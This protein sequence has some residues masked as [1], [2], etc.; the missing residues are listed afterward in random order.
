MPGDEEMDKISS[1]FNE[2]IIWYRV[3][4]MEKTSGPGGECHELLSHLH[5]N[6]VLLIET[7]EYTLHGGQMRGLKAD[8][9]SH[10]QAK[11]QR[12]GKCEGS[13]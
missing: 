10:A 4:Y 11:A 1:F 2:P 5:L 6:K 8:R 3:R 9:W 7:G 12:W 13:S